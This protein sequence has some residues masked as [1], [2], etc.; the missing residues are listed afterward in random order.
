MGD[1]WREM[2]VRGIWAWGRPAGWDGAAGLN[3]RGNG[4]ID[5]VSCAAGGSQDDP[6]RKQL[7]MCRSDLCMQDMRDQPCNT[8]PDWET[9]PDKHGN[10][11][12][13]TPSH[14]GGYLSAPHCLRT[15]CC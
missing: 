15:D 1:N 9:H 12:R 3:C 2:Q 7:P 6:A 14:T 10:R 13:W 11:A 5:G 8:D 4:S